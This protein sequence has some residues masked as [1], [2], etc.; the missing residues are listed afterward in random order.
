MRKPQGCN[1]ILRSVVLFTRMLWHNVRTFAAMNPELMMSLITDGAS[2]YGYKGVGSQGHD[3]GHDNL[4]I[5]LVGTKIHGAKGR[6]MFIVDLVLSQL[7]PDDSNLMCTLLYRSLLQ[8]QDNGKRSL[9]PRL[10]IQCDGVGTNWGTISFGFVHYLVLSQIGTEVVMA[11]NPVGNTHEDIDGM[12]GNLRKFLD[13]KRW[14]T[15]DE[16]SVLIKQCFQHENVIV[17]IITDS[18]DF[19]KWL[20]PCIDPRLA[21]YSRHGDKNFHPGMHIFRCERNR[22]NNQVVCE[23]KQYQSDIFNLVVFSKE[24]LHYWNPSAD[25]TVQ[26][27]NTFHGIYHRKTLSELWPRPLAPSPNNGTTLPTPRER[28]HSQTSTASSGNSMRSTAATAPPTV[29]TATVPIVSALESKTFA[30]VQV[31]GDYVTNTGLHLC[32]VQISDLADDLDTTD[33]SSQIPVKWWKPV[34]DLNSSYESKWVVWECGRRQDTTPVTRGMIHTT[35]LNLHGSSVLNGA[36]GRRWLKLNS[37]SRE[38][39]K[40]YEESLDSDSDDDES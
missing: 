22:S 16:L 39:G 15:V 2:S 19:K 18:L 7:V 27:P 10:H 4:D 17:N 9:P 30:F 25:L 34:D 21:L 23:F 33:P 11:R 32:V 36:L 35:N 3:S 38:I 31:L 12:F 40:D 26:F 20:Q 28:L 5:K 24:E 13:N 1:S 37:V 6:S 8:W 14:S 29:R